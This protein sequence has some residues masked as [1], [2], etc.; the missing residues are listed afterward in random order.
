MSWTYSQSSGKLIPPYG[1]SFYQGYSGAKPDGYNNPSMQDT[2][3][4]GPIPQGWYTLDEPIEGTEH[5]PY[6]IPL[7]PDD[8]NEMFGRSG[9]YCHGDDIADPG[10]ASEGCLIQ[11]KVARVAMWTGPDHRLQV[12]A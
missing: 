3:D 1:T 12:V 7:I 9:F 5:G 10:H 8:T 4:I 2:H 6:A 11:P